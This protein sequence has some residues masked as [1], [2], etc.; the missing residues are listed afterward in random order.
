MNQKII[1]LFK[2]RDK[3]IQRH[4]KQMFLSVQ[5]GEIA[6]SL[7]TGYLT[8]SRLKS[9][10]MFIAKEDKIFVA[11]VKETYYWDTKLS[12]TGYLLMRLNK[13]KENYKIISICY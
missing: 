8:L 7:S 2:L 12:H 9:H 1:E 13:V 6:G 10:V 3:A 4:D 11:L 5:T